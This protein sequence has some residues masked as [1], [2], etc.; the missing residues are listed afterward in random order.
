MED[1]KYNE[2]TRNRPEGERLLDAPVV[3]L[4]LNAS[5]A[6]IKGEVGYEKNDRNAITLFHSER[7]R[8]VLIALH[9][10]AEITEHAVSGPCSILTIDGRVGVRAG[11]DSY[12][13]G[14]G[15]AL[16]LQDAMAHSVKADAESVILLTIAAGNKGGDRF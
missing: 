1:L 7:M 6:Q 10:G 14:P 2:S 15:E 12:T 8:I 3:P 4:N 16:A 5:I 11:S 9:A 13:L